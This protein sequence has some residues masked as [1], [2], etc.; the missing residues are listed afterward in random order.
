MHL[1]MVKSWPEFRKEAASY[2]LVELTCS[3]S[4]TLMMMAAT[5][6]STSIF[7]GRWL[8]QS[9]VIRKPSRLFL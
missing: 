8:Q 5:S 9:L 4:D 3:A 1:G 7:V 2:V 6:A